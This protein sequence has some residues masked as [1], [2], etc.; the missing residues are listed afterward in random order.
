MQAEATD[1]KVKATGSFADTEQLE[2]ELARLKA[3]LVSMEEAAQ[4]KQAEII[5][6]DAVAGAVQASATHGRLFQNKCVP[7]RLPL[8]VLRDRSTSQPSQGEGR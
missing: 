3:K 2:V 4:R 6:V 8:G 5:E 1:W 7:N